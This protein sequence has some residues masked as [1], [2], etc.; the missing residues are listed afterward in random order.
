M[1]E[2]EHQENKKISDYYYYPS[3][4]MERSIIYNEDGTRTTKQWYDNG[5]L[6]RENNSNGVSYTYSETGVITC[7]SLNNGEPL[8]KG[9][10]LMTWLYSQNG[11]L[12]K[13]IKRYYYD[14]LD[15]RGE[16][17]Y[18]KTYYESG[19]LK[20]EIDFTNGHDNEIVKSYKKNGEILIK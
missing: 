6:M 8:Q 7:K 20:T 13:E 9:G 19:E 17:G 15:T 14:R 5:Q 12:K 10:F 16:R 18:E 2:A 1:Q 3:G 11:S 4:N